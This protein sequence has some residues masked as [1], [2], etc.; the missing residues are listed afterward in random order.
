MTAATATRGN[1]TLSVLLW[2]GIA[3]LLLAPAIA[4]RFDSG[5]DW[6]ALDFIAAAFILGSIGAAFE[7][8]L[9]RDGTTA[10]RLGAAVGL[11]ALLLLVWINLA[12]GIIGSEQNDANLMY[13]GVITIVVGGACLSRFRPAG[14]AVTA[15]G[16]AVA[17]VAVALIA[18]ATGAAAG[19][20]EWPS[21]LIGVTAGL[22]ALWLAAAGLFRRAARAG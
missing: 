2:G 4:M 10:Y 9:R 14:L 7:F 18:L 21:D 15:V 3:A 11:L 20:D 17:Q 5:V 16:A 19:V 22:T 1:R 12:V 8:L 13:A 6:T